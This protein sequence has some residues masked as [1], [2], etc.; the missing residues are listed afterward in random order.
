MRKIYK[1]DVSNIPAD[2]VEEYI[3]KI[4]CKLQGKSYNYKPPSKLKRFIKKYF[5][6]MSGWA[7]TI[8]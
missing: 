4:K 2:E 7:P 5:G 6:W 3:R 1:I 8:M